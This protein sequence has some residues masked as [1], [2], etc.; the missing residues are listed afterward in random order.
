MNF[1][2][3]GGLFGGQQWG[4]PQTGDAS[5]LGMGAGQSQSQGPAFGQMPTQTQDPTL[6]YGGGFGQTQGPWSSMN[7][8]Q[9]LGFAS[10]A[11]S[12]QTS[13]DLN[14]GTGFGSGNGGQGLFNGPPHPQNPGQGWPGLMGDPNGGMPQVGQAGWGW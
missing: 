12:P 4:Q 8:G 11:Q 1:Q 7:V 9:N 3:Q 13:T 2:G 14:Y 5:P 6:N 10:Q